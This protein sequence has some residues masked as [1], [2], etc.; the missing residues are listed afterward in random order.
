VTFR[1]E[2]VSHGLATVIRKAHSDFACSI[3]SKIVTA[4]VLHL[5]PY[6]YIAEADDS[7]NVPMTSQETASR[8]SS[9][10]SECKSDAEHNLQLRSQ[11]SL[12]HV[13][14]LSS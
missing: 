13:S 6:Q 5:P 11:N 3:V 1:A 4:I 12:A 9:G 10:P 7:K 8:M 14:H 2:V